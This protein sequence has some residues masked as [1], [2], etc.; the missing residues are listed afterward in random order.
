MYKLNS[1]A[2]RKTSTIKESKF[3]VNYLQHY[4]CDG[5]VVERLPYNR[6]VVGSGPGRVIPKILKM[7]LTAFSSGARNKRM[8]W[9]S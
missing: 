8:E 2:A 6:K 5:P 9:E 4:R 3:T 7:V 1:E